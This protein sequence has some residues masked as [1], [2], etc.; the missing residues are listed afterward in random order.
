MTPTSI[1]VFTGMVIA[2]KYTKLVNNALN[3]AFIFAVGAFKI[4]AG[5]K[6]SFALRARTNERPIFVA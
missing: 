1:W 4:F 2:K 3:R 5:V 6:L